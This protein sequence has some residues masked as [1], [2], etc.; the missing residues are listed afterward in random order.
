MTPNELI[1]HINSGTR[2]LVLNFPLNLR[3]R[4]RTN[5][6][7]DDFL[8]ELE[9]NNTLRAVVC[10]TPTEL[11]I[12]VDN[13]A[14]LVVAIGGIRHLEA[15][16]LVVFS[17]RAA[18]ILNRYQIVA[19]TVSRARSLRVLKIE[20]FGIGHRAADDVGMI[21]LTIQLREHEALRAFTWRDFTVGWMH[22][23]GTSLDP[24]LVALR[25]CPQLQEVDITSGC[26]S[27]VVMADLQQSALQTLRLVLN[28]D[29]WSPVTNGIRDGLCR[30]RKLILCIYRDDGPIFLD[31]LE[32][33]LLRTADELVEALAMAIEPDNNPSLTT[34]AIDFPVGSNI[35]I[36]AAANLATALTV[37]RTL[38]EFSVASANFEADS[39]DAF[40][41]MLSVNTGVVLIL[42]GLSIPAEEN[43]ANSHTRMEIEQRLNLAGRRRPLSPNNPASL[44]AARLVWVDVLDALQFDNGDG[45]G[46]HFLLSCLYKLIRDDPTMTII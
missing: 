25:T 15:L 18:V 20:L 10:A 23:N 36:P 21:A 27:A 26:A 9:S 14:R 34:L 7:F 24:V 16:S 29:Q 32:A 44:N 2:E 43:L 46:D 35:G 3:R 17:T 19:N 8:V 28:M 37:N 45:D 1:G 5:L 11:G 41:D 13:W 22:G 42:P 33:F 30:V 31:Q 40:S 39:Y 12:S 6:D 4:S 38:C